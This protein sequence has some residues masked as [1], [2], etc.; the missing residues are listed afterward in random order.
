MVM[1]RLPEIAIADKGATAISRDL[2]GAD[3][4]IGEVDLLTL[5][6]I[7]CALRRG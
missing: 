5:T 3:Y 2:S 7:E 6:G 4:R 1:R